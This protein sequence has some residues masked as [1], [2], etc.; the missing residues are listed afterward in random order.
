MNMLMIKLQNQNNM[1]L[2]LKLHGQK[3]DRQAKNWS[4]DFLKEMPGYWEY[5]YDL[6]K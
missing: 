1:Q 3:N 5:E 2:G 4:L 6:E